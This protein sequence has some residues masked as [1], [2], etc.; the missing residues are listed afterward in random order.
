MQMQQQQQQ[1]QQQQS[2][3]S[4]SY[5]KAASISSRSSTSS[6]V[7]GGGGSSG[8][9]NSSSAAM[10]V[11]G[12]G[13]RG[14][15]GTMVQLT[16]QEKKE[17]ERFLIFTRVLM[18]YL[19]QRDPQMHLLAKTQIKECYEKNKAGDPAFRSLTTS[20]NTRLRATVGDVYWKKA[21]DYLEHFIRQ[22]QDKKQHSSSS[23]GG[24]SGAMT[25]NN[26]PAPLPGISGGG[27]GAAPVQP[28]AIVPTGIP[29]N[30]NISGAPLT[31]N[32]Q[33]TF[34]PN[35]AIPTASTSK[36]TAVVEKG[37][38][39][40][41]AAARKE[42]K[43]QLARE[44][45][46]K[47]KKEAAAKAA[48]A[49]SSGGVAATANV[50]VKEKKTESGGSK[51][52]KRKSVTKSTPSSATKKK[53]SQPAEPSNFLMESI[54]HATMLDVKRLPNI[55]TSKEYKFDVSLNE[56]QKILLYGGDEEHQ[57]KMKEITDASTK[58]L[59][60]D[61]DLDAKL[62]DAGVP[63]LP[64]KIPT[65][66]NGWGDRNI[67]SV[68]NAWAKVRLP[69]SE[70]RRAKLEKDASEE[71]TRPSILVAEVS[72]E[73]SGPTSP[74]SV[75]MDVL[76][77]ENDTTNHVWF[78]ESR[79]EQDMTLALLSEATEKYLKSTIE[80]ALAKARLRHNLDGVRLWHTLQA[81]HAAAASATISTAYTKNSTEDPPF[82]PPPA[83]IR[84][85]CDVRR[86][87]ALSEG[88]A[89][90]VYQRMEEALSRQNDGSYS[91][92][93]N[94]HMLL[95]STSMADFA[96]KAPLK[97]AVQRAEADAKRKFAVFGG[98]DSTGPPLGRVPK[99]AKVTLQDLAVSSLGSRSSTIGLRRKRFRAGFNF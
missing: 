29:H 97:H 36:T 81:H 59:D 67:L 64:S 90:K 69:E 1:Q 72:E 48:A 63:P 56:E 82:P 60:T 77:I 61:V 84:L 8:A 57:R 73:R 24:S 10:A 44:N 45:R 51:T 38:K 54:D 98:V 42:Q 71:K 26:F 95:E 47:K 83:F 2:I 86:Q 32:A 37:K 70:L 93:D 21:Q 19:E 99:E 18:K 34:A 75:A 4:S 7:G 31:T 49:A 17:K 74:S 40:M 13:E 89:T 11:S 6:G 15:E 9:T 3:P 30:S 94:E 79:A 76:T 68:R 52:A 96:K 58:A 5:N 20:M 43:N 35:T 22:K 53:Q 87:I 62:K 50:K 25:T 27:G 66:Y 46:A 85:G 23:S 78:N 33:V 91:N 88:N 65:M 80:S 55:F 92:D 16:D 39:K 12:G 14:R 28:P 41:D